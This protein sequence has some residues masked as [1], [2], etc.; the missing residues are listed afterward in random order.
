MTNFFPNLKRTVNS[1][2]KK[3]TNPNRKN[4]EEN[5]KKTL[6]IELLK[7]NA[8]EKSFKN[9]LRKTIYM[10][11]KIKIRRKIRINLEKPLKYK[12]KKKPGKL[13]F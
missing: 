9:S 8:E 11:R 5:C 7:T 12:K 10:G 2:S 4:H 6:I 3:L 13:E 1:G